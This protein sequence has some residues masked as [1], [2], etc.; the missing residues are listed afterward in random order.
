MGSE[1]KTF[2]QRLVVQRWGQTQ[3]SEGQ[4]TIGTTPESLTPICGLFLHRKLETEW[5]LRTVFLR[6][7]R[8]AIGQLLPNESFHYS[9]N[10][11]EPGAP[12]RH[13]G[14]CVCVCVCVRVRV[15]VRA[16]VCLGF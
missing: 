11:C 15:R 2:R 3:P 10:T 8:A 9:A 5:Q 7:P 12:R 14:A 4:P 13:P 16:C 1:I 6:I